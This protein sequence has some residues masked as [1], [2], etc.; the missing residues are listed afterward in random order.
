MLTGLKGFVWSNR[1]PAR[2]GR[3]TQPVHAP[4]A[5]IAPPCEAP[6]VE[7][8]P[9]PVRGEV[10]RKVQGAIQIVAGK[11]VQATNWRLKEP[12]PPVR[13]T[14]LWDLQ[15]PRLTDPEVR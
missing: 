13:Y 7:I 10:S 6:R 2:E 9:K 3:P 8:A 11:E 4:T 5:A 12:H 14:P 15:A 1:G